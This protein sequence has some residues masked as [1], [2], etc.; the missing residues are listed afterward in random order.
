MKFE[1]KKSDMLLKTVEINKQ[2]ENYKIEKNF[3]N[4]HKSNMLTT[5]RSFLTV[6]KI[7]KP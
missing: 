6:Y 4:S 1:H 2:S 3:E 5:E 7:V